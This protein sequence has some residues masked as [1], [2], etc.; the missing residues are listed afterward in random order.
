[1]KT[2]RY[3]KIV[4]T[5]IAAELGWIAL[6][7]GAQPLSAQ[8]PPAPARV[9]IT[10]IELGAN[11]LAYLPVG[12]AGG[13]N[14][15]RLTVAA[16]VVVDTSQQPLRVDVPVPLDVRNVGPVRIEPGDRPIRTEAVP[17]TPAQRP[18]E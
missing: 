16:R 14:D 9:I 5:L 6:T 8:A 10:G 13:I 2:D 18:G 11:R 4:L 12:I 7:H 3:L 15:G 17:Y 1:M